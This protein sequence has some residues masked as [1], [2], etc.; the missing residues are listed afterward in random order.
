MSALIASIVRQDFII[1]LLIALSKGLAC[2]LR[3]LWLHRGGTRFLDCS[4][5][6]YLRLRSH[7]VGLLG[8]LHQRILPINLV[9][10]ITR[11]KSNLNKTRMQ[12]YL[13]FFLISIIYNFC[14]L[15]M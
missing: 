2:R 10:N 8:S 7:R 14:N 15:H 1:F 3:R 5:V 13:T 12:S 9:L 11:A 6:S 4:E